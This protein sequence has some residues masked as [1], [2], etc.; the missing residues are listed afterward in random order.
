MQYISPVISPYVRANSYGAYLKK[1][2]DCENNL[3][4]LD[5]LN[6]DHYENNPKLI[7]NYKT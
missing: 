3:N 5:N 2:P 6:G 4:A 7:K 1:N